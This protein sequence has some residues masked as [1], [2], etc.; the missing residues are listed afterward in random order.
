MRVHGE[1]CSH[2][3]THCAQEFLHVFE[4]HEGITSG[5]VTVRTPVLSRSR[6]TA[7]VK[8]GRREKV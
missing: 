4:G 8:I 1:L 6:S 7:A 2:R 5:G 3:L